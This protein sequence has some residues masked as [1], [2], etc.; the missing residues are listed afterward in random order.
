KYLFFSSDELPGY[1]GYDVFYCVKE[2]G[3]WSNP[4]NL[5]ARVNTVN[6]DTHFRLK[7]N[8]AGA[9]YA[10]VADQNGFFSYDL[11]ELDLSGLDFPFL[12]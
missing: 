12:K 1:G 5:G 3:T 8:N 9:T 4:V 2:N 6:N 10:S 7:E 11:F